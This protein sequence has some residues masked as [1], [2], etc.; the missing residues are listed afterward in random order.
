MKTKEKKEKKRK[1]KENGLTIDEAKPIIAATNGA[2]NG[3]PLQIHHGDVKAE[4]RKIKSD[5]YGRNWRACR[6]SSSKC[7]IGSSTRA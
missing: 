6:L 2:T 1:V 5:T 3:E 4:A 7:R